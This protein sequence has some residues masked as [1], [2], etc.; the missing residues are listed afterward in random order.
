V[1]DDPNSGTNREWNTQPRCPCGLPLP[2]QPKRENY[3]PTKAPRTRKEDRHF[4]PIL[5]WNAL[6]VVPMPRETDKESTWAIEDRI[7]GEESPDSK[8]CSCENQRNPRRWNT[9]AGET[10]SGAGAT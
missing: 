1:G 5:L 6:S 7:L 4:L 8:C 2:Q 9:H 3:P 10:T